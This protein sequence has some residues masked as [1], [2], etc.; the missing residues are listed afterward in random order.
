[1]PCINVAGESEKR[2][3]VG[4]PLPAYEIRMRVVD[5]YT[6]D[7]KAIDVRGKGLFDAYYSPWKTR[8]E[9]MP[10]GWFETGDLGKLD[11]DGYL[12]IMGRSKEV[13]SVGG[14]KVF[15]QEIETV[16]ESHLAVKEACVFAQQHD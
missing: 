12:Y 16:L 8:A 4:R 14:M 3:S 7:L 10:Q 9:L 5:E 15:P 2:G 1:L 11:E 13:I 6:N